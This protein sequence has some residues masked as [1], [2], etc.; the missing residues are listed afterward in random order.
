MEFISTAILVLVGLFLL[1]KLLNNG[2]VVGALDVLE[3]TV[4]TA[5]HNTSNSLQTIRN[6]SNHNTAKSRQKL[7]KKTKKLGSVITQKEL[8]KI[9]K[10]TKKPKAETGVQ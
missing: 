6:E 1:H 4:A 5:S 3:E 8:N 9:L 2:A 10:G 7:E